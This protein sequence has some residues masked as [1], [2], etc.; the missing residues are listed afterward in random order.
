MVK[1]IAGVDD[2][3]ELA[4]VAIG[5]EPG[6]A[7]ISTF[8]MSASSRLTRSRS[9]ISGDTSTAT[10]RAAHRG[11]GECELTRTAPEIHDDG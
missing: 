4:R 8:L 1:R 3:G 9:R 7:A 11:G 10:T 6:H 5:E 2:V